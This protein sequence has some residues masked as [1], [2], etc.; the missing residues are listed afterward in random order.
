LPFPPPPV[1]SRLSFSLIGPLSPS[2]VLPKGIVGLD[3][4]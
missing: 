2:M 3:L 4:S 1:R